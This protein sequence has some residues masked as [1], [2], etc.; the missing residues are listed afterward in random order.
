[1]IW[2]YRV[3]YFN[4]PFQPWVNVGWVHF[5]QKHLVATPLWGKTGLDAPQYE[6]WYISSYF[7]HNS[8][9]PV[10]PCTVWNAGYGLF[11]S[12]SGNECFIRKWIAA[13]DLYKLTCCI[14]GRHTCN[15]SF[16]IVNGMFCKLTLCSYCIDCNDFLTIKVSLSKSYTVKST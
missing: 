13:S 11:R 2:I 7:Q 5:C 6:E 15:T 10:W 3:L 4:Q 8:V 16:F 9:K 14:C 12:V 1:M